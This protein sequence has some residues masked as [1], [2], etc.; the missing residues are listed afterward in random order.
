MTR[1]FRMVMCK[2]GT[3][4]TIVISSPRSS[5]LP[6]VEGLPNMTTRSIQRPLAFCALLIA[7]TPW[8][9]SCGG[10]N[11]GFEIAHV[12]VTPNPIPTSPVPVVPNSLSLPG[13]GEPV[14]FSVEMQMRDSILGSPSG[15]VLKVDVIGT[16]TNSPGGPLTA[17]QCGD[18]GTQLIRINCT[19]TATSTESRQLTCIG[20]DLYVY[21]VSVRPGT[22]QFLFTA[23]TN[24]AR[25]T[26]DVIVEIK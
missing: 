8:L 5:G 25:D 24:G 16:G 6:N 22:Y 10:K 4:S 14:P 18:C 17:R 9:S 13:F 7:L 23:S 2:P 21:Q 19:S 20:Q 1:T 3:R 26:D 15:Y 12:G 11:T